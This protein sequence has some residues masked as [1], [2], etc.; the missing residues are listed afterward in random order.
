[1]LKKIA[2]TLIYSFCILTTA[3]ATTT[4]A[5]ATTPQAAKT[6]TAPV[7]PGRL[8]NP[9]THATLLEKKLAAMADSEKNPISITFYRP[10]YVLP[11]YY[12]GSPYTAIYRGN[13]PNGQ[14][15]M[16]SELK[17]QLSLIMPITTYFFNDKTSLSI[18]YTQLNYWQVYA[19]SQYFRET[20]YEPEIIISTRLTDNWLLNA[21]IDHQSNGRGGSLERSWNR[22][23]LSVA[24]SGENWLL[25]V[26]VWDLIFKS[27]SSN[28][29]NPEIAHYLGYDTTVFAY[30]F[31]KLVASVQ[32]SN[33]ES[34]FARGNIVAGLSYPI[35]RHFRIYVQYFR[36][37]GQS[38]IEYNHKTQSAG[39]GFALNDWI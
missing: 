6:T 8:D 32:V 31:H 18:A 12:T 2:S 10:T 9:G 16:H 3:N 11:F 26:K 21:S 13:T 22:A 15:I 36:G 14:S 28:L 4:T 25:G 37:F 20:N 5:P 33:I 24:T 34:G 35:S 27:Q 23:I 7:Q 38:L 17:A 19:S 1:M 30:N 29:H 39:I